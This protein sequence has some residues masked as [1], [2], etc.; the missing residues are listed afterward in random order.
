MGKESRDIQSLRIKC[1]YLLSI[2]LDTWL[3]ESLEN[4][5]N[6]CPYLLLGRKTTPSPQQRPASWGYLVNIRALQAMWYSVGHAKGITSVL[7]LGCLH[8]KEV[9]E[10]AK[11]T[12]SQHSYKITRTSIFI[13]LSSK[14]QRGQFIQ[15]WFY[16]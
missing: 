8:T 1:D 10:I 4:S 12:S 7:N 6:V 11:D 5:S 3:W 15:T 2:Q 13:F 16:K 9:E 14:Q